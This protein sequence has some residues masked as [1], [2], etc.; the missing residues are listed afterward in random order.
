MSG[1]LSRRS[2][3]QSVGGGVLAAGALSDTGEAAGRERY[4]L[5]ASEDAS[6]S[7]LEEQV[8]TLVPS[9]AIVDRDEVLAFTVATVPA[10]D[11][12]DLVDTFGSADTTRY[13]ERDELLT[14]VTPSVGVSDVAASRSWAPERVR[15]TEAW[16]ETLGTDVTVAVVDTGVEYFHEDLRERFDDDKGH[17]LVDDDPSPDPDERYNRHG[18]NV[19]GVVAAT[20]G[21]GEGIDGISNARLLS[22]KAS[23][24]SG[25][26]YSSALSKSIRWAADNGADVINFSWGGGDSLSETRRAAGD[27]AVERGALVVAAAGN[28]GEDTI[29]ATAAYERTVGVTALDRDGDLASFS[30]YGP[31]TDL[32]APG[33]DL[34]TTD[35][36]PDRSRWGDGHGYASFTGTSASAPVVAGVA[37]LALSVDPSLGPMELK[38]RLEA[39]ARDIGLP[40]EKQGAGLVDALNVVDVADPGPDATL[41]VAPHHPDPREVI[42][43]DASDSSYPDG[44][45][46]AHEWDLGDG[47]T[48]TGPVVEHSYGAPGEYAVELTVSGDDGDAAT[49]RET[50]TVGSASTVTVE[51]DVKRVHQ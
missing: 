29:N 43:L 25:G 47:T 36:D 41:T 5:G 30:N 6:L 28:D 26:A 48:A 31:G 19:A 7:Y 37:A 46:E 51:V 10:S 8:Q 42:T 39:G 1:E 33:V 4:V 11:E 2:F 17:S 21:N 12:A 9:A 24:S 27:H 34:R 20:R 45:I 18:T 16:R 14:P 50:V 23:G 13:V 3:L 44:S 15:A 35:Y 40:V 49:A 32:V 38:Q 22:V